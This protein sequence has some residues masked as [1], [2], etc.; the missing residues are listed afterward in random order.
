MER[1][2]GIMPAS[3][4]KI[5]KIY[6]DDLGFKII[7]QAGEHGWSIM[8]PGYSGATY[9]DIDNTPEDNFKLALKELSAHIYSFREIKSSKEAEK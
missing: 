3:E 8:Y 9:D 6:E 2:F 7:V 5:E 4:V 1:F